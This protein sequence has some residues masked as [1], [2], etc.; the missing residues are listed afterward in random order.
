MRGVSRRPGPGAA[1]FVMGLPLLQ[2]WVPS[3]GLALAAPL[4]IGLYTR[5]T[6]AG[7]L[8]SPLRRA[9]LRLIE[10][11]PGSHV[12]EL[13]S[14]LGV[15]RVALRH[16]LR[17]LEAHRLAV[18][19]VEGRVLAWFAHGE[20]PDGAAVAAQ[21]ALKDPTRRRVLAAAGRRPEGA[22][23]GDIVGETALPQRLVS[24]HLARLEAVG[25][26]RGDGG[27]PQRFAA[28]SRPAEEKGGPAGAG[29]AGPLS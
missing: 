17:M 18:A 26:V 14:L 19:R 8:Q 2:P 23:Q 25:L 15:G 21:V 10:D 6:R 13:S 22:T 7:V 12:S 1:L 4:C 29:P 27:R 3:S 24:Y 9:L 11:R 16:H 28:A 5:L 20:A